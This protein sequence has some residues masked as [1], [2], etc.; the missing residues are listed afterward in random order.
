MSWMWNLEGLWFMVGKCC[1]IELRVLV[2]KYSFLEW[3]A[4]LLNR[5]LP[6]PRAELWR[7]QGFSL[8]LS[9]QNSCQ[10]Q[11]GTSLF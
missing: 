7:G 10:T 5:D 2:C 9:S 3:Y 4:W 11:A 1:T 6:L 8:G